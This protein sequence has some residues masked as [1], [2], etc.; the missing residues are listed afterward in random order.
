MSSVSPAL[1]GTWGVQEVLYSLTKC[2]QCGKLI[3]GTWESFCV[4]SYSSMQFYNYFKII[5]LIL[6]NLP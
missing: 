1:A 3:K 2:H 6:K 4:I 5:S